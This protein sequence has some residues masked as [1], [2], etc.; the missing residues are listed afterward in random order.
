[1]GQ[2]RSRLVK[3]IVTAREPNSDKWVQWE[4][5]LQG[6]RIREDREDWLNNARKYFQDI[7]LTRVT[8]AHQ[9]KKAAEQSK[10]DIAREGLRLLDE[11]LASRKS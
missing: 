5:S 7:K 8:K 1:M 10:A 11:I 6:N 4:I 2:I 3:F 9:A